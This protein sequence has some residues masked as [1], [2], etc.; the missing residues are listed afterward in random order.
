MKNR[1]LLLSLAAAVVLFFAFY[2]P[3]DN[4]QKEAALMQSILTELNYYHYQPLDINDEFSEKVYGLFLD[5]LD[6]GRRWLTQPDVAQLDAWKYKLDDQAN[7]GAFT[8]LD[9]AIALQEN[10]IRKTQAWYREILEKPFNFEGNESVETDGEKKGF[11]TDDAALKDYWYKS[12]KWETLTRLATNVEKKEKGEEDYKDKTMAQLEEDARKDVL[13]VYD[14]WYTRLDK[15]KRTDHLSTYLNAFTNIFDPHTEYYEP[16]DKQNFD[17]GMSGRLEGIGARLQTDGEY[18]KVSEIIVGGPAWKQGVL[19]END[20]IMKVAQGDEP[21]W[22]DITGMVI[23]DVVQLIRGKPETK[24]RL[25][26]KKADGG[27]EEIVIVRDVVILE[28]GFAKS[29]IIETPQSEKIGYIRLPKFYADFQDRNGRRCSDDI[30]IELE[31]LKQAQVD[32]II[33]D[34]RGNGG[35]SLRDVV[36]MG[37]FFVE[38][39]PIVQVKSRSR[40]P[41]VLTDDDPK[42]QYAGPLIIMVNQ[43]SASA[44]EILAAAMQD[45]GR[46]IIVGSPTFGKGT[47]QRFFDLDAVIRGNSDVKPLGEVKLT[48][49]KFFRVDGGSTQLKGVTPDILIPDNW[50]YIDTGEKEEDFPMQWTQIDPVPYNQK[51]YS[52][53]NLPKIREMAAYRIKN[54]DVFKQVDE[55][56]R[57]IK[58]QREDTEHALNL[59]NYLAEDRKF[60][61]EDEAYEKLFEPEV[62][63]GVSNLA[64]DISAVEADESKKARNDEWLKGVKKDVYLK[65]TLNIMHDMITMK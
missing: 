26:V 50:F 27:T 41:E 47:V 63:T 49:Q 51:V 39:G 20:K 15:R 31:K 36:K 8:F 59:D 52:L 22:T 45:Y 23:N 25:F 11:A 24:V 58:Q 7:E 4:A 35:G 55:R 65:E 34:L 64:A 28:E 21:E 56:A 30:E 19:K 16:I 43:F 17:I 12:L 42:V 37:G 6:G 38:E 61:A 2:P 18:T 53:H 10:G 32:G 48:V 60:E 5:R 14:S 54:N 40:N 29:L 62:V 13:K 44:S 33:L 57:R 46:A 1:G 3:V 9:M